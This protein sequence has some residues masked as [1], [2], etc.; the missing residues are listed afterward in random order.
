[1]AILKGTADPAYWFSFCMPFLEIPVM[2][3]A[4]FGLLRQAGHSFLWKRGKELSQ[5]CSLLSEF[6]D[7]V[8]AFSLIAG[9]HMIGSVIRVVEIQGRCDV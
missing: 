6:A 8:F 4:H 3:I 7:N 2:S 5:R 9:G 1:V